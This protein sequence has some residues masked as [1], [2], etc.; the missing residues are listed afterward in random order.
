[1]SFKELD[2]QY[3]YSSAKT[4]IV[5][6]F[7][8]PVLSNAIKYDRICGY[9][10]SSSLAIAAKGLK[11]FILNNGKMRLLC[12]VQLNK[13]DLNSILNFSDIETLISDSFL[14]NLDNMEDE[15]KKNHV[16]LLAWMLANN[17]LE[18]KIGIKKNNGN[19]VAGMLHSKTGALFD[20]ENNCIL[21][22]GSNN[23]TASGWFNNIE[24]FK[25]FFSWDET[26]KYMSDDLEEF[27]EFWNNQNDSLEVVDIPKAA[28]EGLIKLAPKSM[29]DL[30]KL[31]LSYY[32][33]QGKSNKMDTRRLYS[34]QKKALD[35]WFDNGCN[36]IFEMA[37]GTGKTFTALKCLEKLRLEENNLVTVISCPYTHLIDQWADDIEKFGWD[38]DILYGSMGQHWKNLLSELIFNLRLG[39][40][41]NAIILT[42]HNSFSNDVFISE[43]KKLSNNLLLIS[44]EMHHLGSLNLREGLLK[45]YEFKLGLSATPSRYMDDEGTDFLLDYFGGIVF[46]FTIFEALIEKN[47]DGK[48]FLTPYYYFPEKISL[49]K[50]ESEEYVV[51]TRKINQLWH[52]DKSKKQEDTLNNLLRERKRIINNAQEKYDKLQEILNRYDKINHL[53]IFCSP[54]QINNVMSILRAMDLGMVHKFTQKEGKIKNDVFDGL[55]ERQYLLKMFDK[56][57]FVA[58]VAIKCLDEGVDIPSADKVIIMSSTNNPREYVQRRGRVLRRFDGKDN[59]SIYDMAVVFDDVYGLDNTINMEKERMLD[60][61]NTA[62]NSGDCIKLLVEWGMFS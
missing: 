50:S 43:I 11:G 52:M 23:E 41:K 48:S 27:E 53:I 56:G 9:F 33:F 35:K 51:L 22:N 20:N 34:H 17:F 45:N 8:N 59:A 55:S 16:K 58:L 60:F 26:C 7:Y 21:F 12:G 30:N 14:K 62:K 32:E 18:I 29:D 39:V 42:T 31:A 57:E 10:D 3:S 47:F 54:E 19:Y 6:D 2:L 25:V 40:K 46:K 49:T 24:K 15:I 28:K 61:I 37:T 1:M 5:D 36:G 44:D 13:D 38:Y 4:N